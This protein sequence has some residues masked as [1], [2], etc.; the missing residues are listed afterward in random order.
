MNQAILRSLIPECQ[1]LSLW[2]KDCSSNGTRFGTGLDKR[3]DTH[4]HL[5]G[6]Q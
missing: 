5:V 4:G 1:R 6:E 3:F 2:P